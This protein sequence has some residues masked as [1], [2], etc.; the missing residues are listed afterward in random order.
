MSNTSKIYKA[1]ILTYYSLFGPHW[2][3]YIDFMG[4]LMRW[5]MRSLC[6]VA[7]SAVHS[8]PTL[9]H[10]AAVCIPSF[11]PTRKPTGKQWEVDIEVLVNGYGDCWY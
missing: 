2:F 8:A 5:H 11:P 7:L 10:G 1:Y 6:A 9:K 4:M 3:D